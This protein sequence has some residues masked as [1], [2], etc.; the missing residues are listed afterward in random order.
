[1]GPFIINIQVKCRDCGFIMQ[2]FDDKYI[3][4]QN[5]LCVLCGMKFTMPFIKLSGYL[6]G[7][8][9]KVEFE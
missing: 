9:I 4:C 2:N 6:P 7:G 3:A 1:M 5:S 8:E